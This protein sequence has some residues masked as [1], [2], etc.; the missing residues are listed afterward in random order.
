MPNEGVQLEAYELGGWRFAVVRNNLKDG[1]GR[2]LLLSC[3]NSE[4]YLHY[5]EVRIG[6]IPT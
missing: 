6:L 2:M 1:R 5:M 3:S 4:L